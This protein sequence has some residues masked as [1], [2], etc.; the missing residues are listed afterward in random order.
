MLDLDT[1]SMTEI[2]RLQEQLQ[3]ALTRRFQCQLLL[4]FTDIV[5]SSAYFGRFG[6]GAG[7]GLQQ[8]HLDLLSPAVQAASGRIVDTAGDGAFCAFASADAAVA[9]VISLQQALAEANA[10]RSREHQLVLRIGL[11]WGAVLSDG[12]DVSGDAVNTCARV[13]SSADPGQVRMSRPAVLALTRRQHLC[14]QALGEVALK[15]IQQPMALVALDW[16][17]AQR[18]PRRLQVEETGELLA[19]PEHDLVCAGRLADRELPAPN[20]LVLKH[21]D[22]QLTRLISRAHFE[23][24][25]HADG[26]RLRAL[27]SQPTLVDGQAVARGVDVAVRAGSRIGVAGV[28]NLRLLAQPLAALGDDADATMLAL[29][30]ATAG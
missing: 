8:L 18:F 30:G 24:R 20:D 2:I 29:S 13:A 15:G 28:L 25:R 11:H 26:L 16:R 9:A 12:Q 7:R 14:G 19:M 6:D 23:L 27:S 4:M 3:Q 5:G 22:A 21:P 1:L 17:D 10:Q